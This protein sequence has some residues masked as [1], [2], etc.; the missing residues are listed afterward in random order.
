MITY[1]ANTIFILVILFWGWLSYYL[2]YE[3]KSSNNLT[4]QSERQEKNNDYN[5]DYHP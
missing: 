2:I 4:N 5:N 3:D 1:I